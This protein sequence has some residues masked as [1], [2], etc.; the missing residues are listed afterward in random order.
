MSTAVFQLQSKY[1]WCLTGTP[2][3][4]SLE[5]LFSLLFFLQVP[6]VSDYSWFKTNII[7]MAHSQNQQQAVKGYMRLQ[8]TYFTMVTF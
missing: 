2:I 3:Q 4:N 8:V 6:E 7:K 5:D 1:R